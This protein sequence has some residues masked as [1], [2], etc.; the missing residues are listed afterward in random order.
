[1]ADF[2]YQPDANDRVSKIRKL[3]DRMDGKFLFGCF[4]LPCVIVSLQQLVLC[5]ISRSSKSWKIILSKMKTIEL[6][7]LRMFQTPI[8][9][10]CSQ[11]HLC[12]EAIYDCSS[13]QSSVDRWFLTSTSSSFHYSQSETSDPLHS[14]YKANPVSIVQTI[15]DEATGEEKQRLVNKHMW[16]A[17]VMAILSVDEEDVSCLRPLNCEESQGLNLIY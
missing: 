16:K 6:S 8:L 7:T 5:K 3:I 14:S 17:D 1:M 2:Q 4:D 10:A 11:C 15:T 9:A 13:H 12:L